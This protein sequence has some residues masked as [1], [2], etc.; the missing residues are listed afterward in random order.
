[1]ATLIRKTIRVPRKMLKEIE[2]SRGDRNFTQIAVWGLRAWLRRHR[3]RRNSQIITRAFAH[4]PE[5]RRGQDAQIAEQASRSGLEVLE[6]YERGH[7]KPAS[8]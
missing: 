2:E 1:M 7:E 5:E 8:G 6:D 4:M 3:R